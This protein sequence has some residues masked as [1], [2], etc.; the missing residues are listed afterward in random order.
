MAYIYRDHSGWILGRVLINNTSIEFVDSHKH[1]GITL[2]DNGQWRTYTEIILAAAYKIVGIMHK[3]KYTFSRTALNQIFISY[4]RPLPLLEYLAIIWD[5]CTIQD[6][7]ALEKLQN[8]AARIVTGLPR[9]TSLDNL[10][11]ECGW[12]YLSERSKFQKLCFM[13][14]CNNGQVPGYISDL[15][16]P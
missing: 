9:S 5:G 14:K 3:L 7:L 16:P 8:K 4:I 11:W 15:I 2:S 12:V 1:L 13:Y 6:K 10:Y